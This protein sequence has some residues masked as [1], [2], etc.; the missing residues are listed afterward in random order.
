M[1]L[2][3]TQPKVRYDGAEPIGILPYVWAISIAMMYTICREQVV[4][5]S[6]IMSILSSAIYMLVYF[7]R[8]R[9]VG[10][11]I[12]T[13]AMTL[14]SFSAI[15]VVAYSFADYALT[16]AE[17]EAMERGFVDFL[18]MASSYFDPYY[19]AAAIIL[20]S[21]I[22]GFMCCYFS[23][24]LPRRCF[25]LLPAFVPT[26][27]SARTAGGLPLW[28]IVLM[29]GAYIPAVCCSARVVETPEVI[30]F[31][32]SA[33]EKKKRLIVSL[34]L[35]VVSVAIAVL[36]P[37][38][39]ETVFRNQLDNMMSYGTGFYNRANALGNFASHSSVNTGDN[40]PSDKVL[41]RVQTEY[42]VNVDRWSFDV[43]SG[44]NGWSPSEY[45]NTGY[46]EWERYAAERSVNRLFGQLIEAARDGRLGE[47]NELFA[48]LP[49][50]D[51]NYSSMMITSVDKT[52]SSVIIHPHGT[53]SV[54]VQDYYGQVYRILTGELFTKDNIVE[55]QYLIR[56][57]CEEPCA[58]YAE[59]FEKVDFRDLLFYAVD[60]GVIDSI[61]AHAFLEE[62]V[63]AQRYKLNCGYEFAA[64]PQ[65]HMLALQITAECDTDYE[66]LCAI[67][68]WFGD[69]GF[70]YDMNFVPA[71][72]DVSYFL[73]ESRRGICSDYA[74]AV[75]L[76]AR[77]AGIPAKYTEGFSLSGVAPDE[78]GC[79]NVTPANAH[80]YTQAYV[81]GC[82]WMNIDA[83]RFVP[84]VEGQTGVDTLVIVCICI[85][86]GIVLLV[87][88][89]IFRKQFSELV[90][91]VSHR[92]KRGSSRVKAIYLRTRL[93][94]A[95]ISDSAEQSLTVRETQRIISDMLSMPSDAGR[96]CCAADE[97][98]YSGESLSFDTKELYKCYKRIYK[99]RRAMKR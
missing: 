43:Y 69:N 14:L 88:I 59:A 11:A 17:G 38:T 73:F 49:V 87:L 94:A 92:F 55:S 82:G 93:I 47:Y 15:G 70:V 3:S 63:E 24:I 23:A 65:I 84:A 99:R 95:Q 62:Y 53:T 81:E 56:Y 6:V 54:T 16:A 46:P 30:Q 12:I 50:Y 83:T 57:I 18:F 29:V 61:T 33:S 68:K 79:Y 2:F 90:F 80:A 71:R 7:V 34:C 1:K 31:D 5:C 77:A 76:L 22:I 60:Q 13:G 9:P 20:F 86:G 97:L 66:K 64:D 67:E 27:L 8:K 40:S 28:I 89:V 32:T 45:Y 19:A 85:A 36:L 51:S 42:T 96:I 75:T 37:K 41:F 21:V 39:G 25:L 48:E 98:L 74:T 26:I 78:N 44:S 72:T 58:E 52:P 10:S 91:F 4:L 35:G